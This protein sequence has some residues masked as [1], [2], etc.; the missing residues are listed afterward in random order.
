MFDIGWT[1]LM[2]IG[3]VAIFAFGPE[4][5]PKL[6]YNLGRIMRRFRYMRYALSNQFESFMEEAE[7]KGQVPAPG[8]DLPKTDTHEH[9]ELEADEGL[10]YDLPEAES[11]PVNEAD[12]KDEPIADKPAA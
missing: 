9:D 10:D 7:K 5:I 6:M 4:D 8:A 12:I 11:R 2:L 3:V 1:E